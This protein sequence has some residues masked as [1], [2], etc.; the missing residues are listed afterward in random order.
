M[1][2]T[3]LRADARTRYDALMDVVR[4]RMTARAFDSLD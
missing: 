4:N 3:A 2:S 1:P